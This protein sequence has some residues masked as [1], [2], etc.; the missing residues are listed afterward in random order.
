MEIVF[1]AIVKHGM[2]NENGWDVFPQKM[3]QKVHKSQIWPFFDPVS[4]I[5]EP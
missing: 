4:P 2:Q 1:P 3:H 5:L